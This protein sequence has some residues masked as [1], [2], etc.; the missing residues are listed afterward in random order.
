MNFSVITAAIPSLHRFLNDLQHGALGTRITE[1]QYE[2]SVGSSNGL[3]GR[4]GLS[5][6]GASRDIKSQPSLQPSGSKLSSRIFS[7]HDCKSANR[8]RK[9]EK[10]GDDYSPEENSTSSLRNN[11]GVMQTWEISI[12]VENKEKR[13]NSMLTTSESRGS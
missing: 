2:L 8:G 13:K 12:E 6:T 11:N 5:K 3:S 7:D 4:F 10:K 9:T 1:H